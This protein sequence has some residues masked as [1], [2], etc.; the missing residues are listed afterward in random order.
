MGGSSE[1]FP[2]ETWEAIA[3][4]VTG[5]SAPE[6]AAALQRWLAEDPAR[7][8]LISALRLPIER[9]RSTPPDVDV[10]AALRATRARALQPALQVLGSYTTSSRPALAWRRWQPALAA[11]AAIVLIVG[12]GLLTRKL[13][14]RGPAGGA[15]VAMARTYSTRPGQRDSLR[16]A[17]GT[18]VLLGPGSVLTV[19]ADFAA[20]RNIILDGEAYFD[21]VHDARR[22]LSV[23]AGAA[24]V[25][26]VGTRF[27]VRS[28]E[29]DRVHV[30]V[31][32]GS[33]L[34]RAR[35]AASANAG[36]V[37]R[38]GDAGTM[39][40]DGQAVV[41]HAP[42][43]PA[44]LAWTRGELVFRGARVGEVAAALRRWYGVELHVPDTALA[45]RH[46]TM[47]FTGEPKGR[48]LEMIALALGA[49]LQ[50][51]GDTA[52]LTAGTTPSSR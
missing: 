28:D 13:L 7:E 36:V 43:V 26:D 9:L 15:A 8:R 41:A 22:P 51:H 1:P 4:F 45:G 49:R 31:T 16:L 27:D 21:V 5:E 48:V 17:D 42:D 50:L 46:L 47:T 44:A 30:V 32:S 12:G 2:P 29:A 24:I 20:V 52:V 37:L 18:S 25:Q 34:L 19:P 23:R 14:L 6:E 39:G 10:E 35:T 33:V 11:A 3:R 40:A 38:A